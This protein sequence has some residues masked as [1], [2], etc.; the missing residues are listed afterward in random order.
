MSEM[1]T[2]D[3]TQAVDD[4]VATITLNRPNKLN[5][6]TPAMLAR[7]ESFLAEI[8][9]SNSIRVV[10]LTG[11]GKAFSVGADIGTWSDLPPL[12]MWR[13]WVRTGQR[14]FTRLAGLRQPVIGVLNGYTFGGGLELALAADFC[15][16]ADHIELAMPEVTLGT[17]PGWAGSA[18]LPERI[19]VAR[20]K[21]MILSGARIDAVTAERW[22]LIN[23]IIPA[24]DLMARSQAIAAQI[25]ANAPLSVQVAKE[26][27][28]GRGAA[29]IALEGLAG[30]LAAHTRD[31]HEGQAAFREKRPPHFTGE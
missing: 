29:S 28:D 12:D 17:L 23:E 24:A 25:A 19:G 2:N 22:N 18:R 27:I 7:L 4:H 9:G 15:I 20:A 14:I 16:A 21:Q 10:L 5:A 6:L 13:W 1:A 26:M 3:I 11:A 30:A 8:E 31:G